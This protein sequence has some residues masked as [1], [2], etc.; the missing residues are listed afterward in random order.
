MSLIQL[1]GYWEPEAKTAKP[2]AVKAMSD[3][4]EIIRM[5]RNVVVL[6]ILY[7]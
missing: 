5:V 7:L 2:I 3:A 1:E 6:R 4:N